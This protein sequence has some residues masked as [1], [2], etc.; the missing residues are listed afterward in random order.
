MV[1]QVKSWWPPTLRGFGESLGGKSYAVVLWRESWS[2]VL[3]AGHFLASAETAKRKRPPRSLGES[4]ARSL[5]RSCAV[6]EEASQTFSGIYLGLSDFRVM[7]SL[8]RGHG[9]HQDSHQL[10]GGYGDHQDFTKTLT[11]TFACGKSCNGSCA[12]GAFTARSL[13]EVLVT[14][15][16]R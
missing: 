14:I 12:T 3:G 5:M 13:G 9:D 6:P 1:A 4:L 2:R 11:K 15:I 16:F 10:L 7:R 8:M